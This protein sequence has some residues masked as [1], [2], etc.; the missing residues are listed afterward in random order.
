M[1]KMKIKKQEVLLKE[2]LLYMQKELKNI[3]SMK[4][5]LIIKMQGLIK[6]KIDIFK[7]VLLK[8]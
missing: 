3:H 8:M 6:L 1:I 2:D 4:F 5:K 7:E